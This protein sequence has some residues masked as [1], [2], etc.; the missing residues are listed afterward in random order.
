MD[1]KNG[2]S[3]SEY[4]SAKIFNNTGCEKCAPEAKDVEGF[5]AFIEKYKRAIAV[6]KAA[7]ENL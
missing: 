3:L 6:E 4:L 5:D 2:L 7:V 1:K